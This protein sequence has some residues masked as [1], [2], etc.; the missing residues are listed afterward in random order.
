MI[1]WLTVEEYAQYS[2]AIAF[3]ITA[4]SLVEFGFSG[5]I[6]ALV[7]Q[8]IH[9]KKLIGNYIKAGRF[10]RNRFFLIV[11]LAS[12]VLFPIITQKHDWGTRM[13]ILLLV[14]ILVNLY[15]TGYTAYYRPPL[16]M[17]KNITKIYN[18]ELSSNLLRFLLIGL[19][20]LVNALNAWLAALAN[21]I[22][23]IINGYRLNK[24]SQNYIEEPEES[25]ES[26][27]KEMWAYISP[28]MP[29]I[30]FA[31]FQSQIVLILV[32]VF[33]E[34][35]NIAEV[36]ALGRVGQLFTILNAGV[37]MLA[38]PYFAQQ[39]KSGLLRKYLIIVCLGALIG[40]L[41]ILFAYL[42]PDLLLWVLGSDYEHLEKELILMLIGSSLGF[43]STLMWGLNSSRKWLYWWM[44][45]ISIPSTLL[46][47]IGYILFLGVETTS[48][49]LIFTI[50][51]MFWNL[52]QR[53][54]VGI[55]GFTSSK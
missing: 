16:Q 1:R 18:I 31:A 47:Q 21:S 45:V 6:I 11:G 55:F 19:F 50:V 53:I 32:S 36:G 24:E 7:G 52:A 17:H 3:Q 49:A 5:A 9:D 41:I 25:L 13:T 34:T 43:T 22:G 14:P 40:A 10:F 15:F 28:I 51:T 8:K 29:G 20:Q 26:V 33:A 46:I 54:I 39:V 4:Q 42:F 48:D 2:L 35:N 12:V 37:G 38:V 27:R 23:V 30:I 44:P